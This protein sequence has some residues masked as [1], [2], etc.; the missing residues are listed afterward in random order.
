MLFFG[1]ENSK[2]TIMRSCIKKTLIAFLITNVSYGAPCLPENSLSFPPSQNKN[3]GTEEQ[4]HTNL[5]IGHFKTIIQPLVKKE[6]NKDLKI[7]VDWENPK[8]N[9][10]ATRDEKNNP[11]IMIY[12]GMARHPLLTDDGFLGILC[13]ELGHHLGGAPKLKRGA[14]T[15]RSWSSVEGQADYFVTSKCLPL[16][17]ESPLMSHNPYK[18]IEKAEIDKA[19]TK[20]SNDLTCTRMALAGM[21]MAKVFASLKTGYDQPAF[22]NQDN[23]EVWETNHKHPRP[24]CRLDTLLA[25]ALCTASPDVGF[26]SSDPSVGACVRVSDEV[27]P[28]IGERPRC[29]YNPRNY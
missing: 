6:L 24:Q 10:S 25:G 19:E 5:L 20:C 3:T 22:D 11:V 12:G 28:V 1:R 7:E 17:Y 13:H 21:S 14:S 23:S 9:A 4:F 16:L 29:W 27:T 8:V 18:S 15:K 26:D 2:N